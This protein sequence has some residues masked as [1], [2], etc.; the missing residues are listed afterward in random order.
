MANEQIKNGVV[1]AEINGIKY[2]K[3]QSKY[4]GDYTKNCGLLGNEI[5]ENFYFL[6]SKD[7][8]GITF[9]DKKLVATRVDETKIE[10][11]MSD[12]YKEYKFE[13]DRNH[14]A[15]VIKF[16]D[17]HEERVSGFLVEGTDAKVATD[18]SLEGNGSSFKPLGLSKMEK[19]GTYAP[20]KEIVNKLPAAGI[21]GQRIVLKDN[22]SN[23]GCLYTFDGVKAIMNALEEVSSQWRVPT[24]EDWAELLN[25]AE[26]CTDDRNHDST[27]VNDWFG[28]NAGARAKS[29][30]EWEKSSRTE[31]G[32]PVGGEDNLP[33][34]GV[35]GTF[36]VLPVGE[37]ES[38]GVLE[39][40]KREGLQGFGRSTTF[41]TSSKVVSNRKDIK[42]FDESNDYGDVVFPEGEKNV[43]TRT[44][45]YNTRKV[46]QESS[47]PDSLYSLRLVRDVATDGQVSD[48]ESILTHNV[49]CLQITNEDTKYNKIWTS[50][51]IGF[52]EPIFSGTSNYLEWSAQSSTEVFYIAEWDGEKWLRKDLKEGDSIVIIDGPKDK[53]GNTI[54][55]HEWRVYKNGEGKYKLVD[56]AEAGT[57]E[58]QKEIER[59]DKRISGETEERK[60]EDAKLQES[61]T[62]ETERA[63]AAEETLTTALSAETK[64][65]IEEISALTIERVDVNDETVREAYKLIGKDGRQH[66]ELIKI[67]KDEKIKTIQVGHMG[68]SVDP[69]TGEI[70]DGPK[71]NHD[72]LQIVYKGENGKYH[73]V[74]IDLDD[75]FK[76]N[77]GNGI[78][79]KD[80]KIHV[81]VNPLSD[82]F[83]NVDESGVILSGVAFNFEEIADAVGLSGDT[84][85]GWD[86]IP[87]GAITSAST[88]VAGAILAL[89][90]RVSNNATAITKEIQDRIDEDI[91]LSG[92][93]QTEINERIADVDAEE[94]RATSAETFLQSEIEKEILD[95]KSG[96][97]NIANILGISGSSESGFTVEFTRP[98]YQKIFWPT[99][100][101]TFKD[102]DHVPEYNEI[103]EQK[104]WD[105]ENHRPNGVYEYIENHNEPTGNN[106]YQLLPG[107][108]YICSADTFI[109]ALQILDNVLWLLDDT[110]EILS[111]LTSAITEIRKDVADLSGATGNIE[112][113]AVRNV[114][115]IEKLSAATQ[116]IETNL[117]AE[118]ARA[119][120][121]ENEI[122]G[123]LNA[124]I[125]RA[126]AKE[127]ELH[128]QDIKSGP[129]DMTVDGIVLEREN[130]DP[131][132]ITFD[133]NFGTI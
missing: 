84:K 119:T 109:E 1:I 79:F 51:N 17:G 63:K 106:Y 65:R 40:D 126:K 81:K 14:G 33:S 10:V 103:V 20:V 96:D 26:Y 42:V 69:E 93:I 131:V 19:T 97:T 41:W 38:I 98:Y 50:F 57:K 120:A 116:T 30:T 107:T 32:H 31:E 125:A 28:K 21:L 29:M 3:L 6:R 87:E 123:N 88:T 37:C 2:F 118:I 24:R 11:D 99:T 133:G 23:Y 58:F 25:A 129:Y 60:A 80:G 104:Y 78:E 86:Y 18:A 4:P 35:M 70:T 44:F 89:D 128:G 68:G 91:R 61:I 73:L 117:N 8:S 64:E 36:H 74:E 114:Q 75:I 122:E 39:E 54:Y 34:T 77:A 121:K 124:E 82:D 92:A 95:R 56:C 105:F 112:K 16:P 100:A 85:S 115:N 101:T 49:K 59:I 71:E 43:Y 45:A 27:I 22:I 7:I 9:E 67:Y 90:N 94:A 55:N 113:L 5:D 110:S 52:T 102:F 12:V 130:G 48:Y 72:A 46:R 132:G 15:L 53:S 62:S 76:L 111:G 13:L 47:K 66:G 127:E 108:S 83:L